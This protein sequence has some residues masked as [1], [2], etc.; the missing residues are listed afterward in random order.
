MGEWMRLKQQPPLHAVDQ[1]TDM[2][3]GGGGGWAMLLGLVLVG[4]AAH[5]C[6]GVGTDFILHPLFVPFP[7]LSLPLPFLV[8]SPHPLISA[9][10][11]WL[12]S[13]LSSRRC[14]LLFSLDAA[15]GTQVFR[16]RGLR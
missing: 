3:G 1:R 13:L 12:V 14:R 8:P 6:G 9:V 2:G 5:V 15:G 16:L 11:C 10:W 4:R 7:P